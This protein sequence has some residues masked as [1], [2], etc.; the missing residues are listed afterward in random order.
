[1]SF[2][3]R[4]IARQPP[5][6]EGPQC[7]QRAWGCGVRPCLWRGRPS[8]LPWPRL[9]R[10]RSI[11][12]STHW[13]RLAIQRMIHAR[14]SLLMPDR[15]DPKPPE[16]DDHEQGKTRQQGSEETQEGPRP[17]SSRPADK[18]GADGRKHASPKEAVGGSG[19]A[20][21][22]IPQCLGCSLW[23]AAAREPPLFWAVG[24]HHAPGH[25]RSCKW[26]DRLSPKK[27]GGYP[28]ANYEA[29][30]LGWPTTGY[31][32]RS[33]R[34]VTSRRRTGQ[35]RIA[36]ALS[37]APPSGAVFDGATSARGFAMLSDA[38]S[39]GVFGVIVEKVNGGGASR[40]L[41]CTHDPGLTVQKSS[42]PFPSA[43]AAAAA[44]VG[45]GRLEGDRHHDGG[46]AGRPSISH[47]PPPDRC[48]PD[49]PAEKRQARTGA[50][51]SLHWSFNLTKAPTARDRPDHAIVDQPTAVLPGVARPGLAGR[52]AK[53]SYRALTRGFRTSGVALTAVA[54]DSK[55]RT[56]HPRSR[57]L[58]RTQLPADSTRNRG[59]G[60]SAL[61][62]IDTARCRWRR[63]S[64]QALMARLAY[65]GHRRRREQG[66]AR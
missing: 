58:S 5:R 37:G 8:S 2:V 42:L 7:S 24:R 57:C 35:R 45:D 10:D 17:Q 60:E 65:P 27:L 40:W 49:A 16:R 64:V 48:V 52:P 55:P 3:E 18:S 15:R 25:D 13:R 59:S 9:S 29:K 39:H 12:S 61:A 26:H 51:A 62:N 31:L 30:G 43:V 66:D 23:P 41:G 14:R 20:R 38:A 11:G 28:P 6:L 21:P 36:R 50:P 54:P 32:D 63:R 53:V 44:R 33:G 46:C 56:C 4:P 1:M 19:K 34:E 22:A 47:R